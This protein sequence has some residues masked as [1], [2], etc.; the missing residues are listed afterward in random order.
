M[1]TLLKFSAT[2]CNPCKQLN[3]TLES[4]DTQN[5]EVITFDIDSFPETTKQW[6]VRG[7]PTLILINENEKELG[8]LSGN[9]K[10]SQIREL[11][12]ND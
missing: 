10:A 7:I 11:L 4:I 1:K 3:K 2:W 6:N 12:E 8:R 5:I 9:I